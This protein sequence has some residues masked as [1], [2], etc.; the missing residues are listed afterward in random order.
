MAYT[1]Q[2]YDEYQSKNYF[3][4]M[5]P[6]MDEEFRNT[7]GSLMLEGVNLIGGRC[8]YI[9]TGA[10][11]VR[12]FYNEALL[13]RAGIRKPPATMEELV[14]D[15]RSITEQ[16]SGEGI[17]GFASNMKNPKSAIDRS[18]TKQGVK[19]Q[20]IKAGYD[21]RQGRYD[22]EKYADLITQWRE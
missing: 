13:E 17:Y 9:P 14:A 10:T 20:G 4:D 12:L 21:F 19:E 7:F 2:L 22:F 11:G 8:Y 6:Y 15:A 1:S 3:A 16:F 5:A 18:I